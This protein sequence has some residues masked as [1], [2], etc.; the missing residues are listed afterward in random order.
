MDE[1]KTTTE[2]TQ[3]G[4]NDGNDNGIQSST[5]GLLEKTTQAVQDLKDQNDRKERLIREEK[6][7][8]ARKMLGGLSEAGEEPEKPKELS[9]KEY[10]EKFARGE[11]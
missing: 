5:T 3:E 9:N 1:Q 8:Y 2:K 10:A 4:T 7:L 11:I 6:D